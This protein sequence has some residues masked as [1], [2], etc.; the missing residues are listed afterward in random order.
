MARI[1]TRDFHIGDILSVTTGALLSPRGMDGLRDIMGF[2]A[3]SKLGGDKVLLILHG[4]CTQSLLAQH[5]QLV[6]VIL[7]TPLEPDQVAKYVAGRAREF[8][9][10]LPVTPFVPSRKP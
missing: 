10:F 3:D 8:G 9:E 6:G 1:T 7:D 5:P 4:P 2:L